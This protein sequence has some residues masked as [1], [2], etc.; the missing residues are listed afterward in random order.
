MYT[1]FRD[2]RIAFIF[3]GSEVCYQDPSD[4]RAAKVWVSERFGFTFGEWAAA[5]RGYLIPGRINFFTGDDYGFASKV[6][7]SMVTTVLVGYQEHYGYTPLEGVYNGCIVGEEGEV[8]LPLHKW[9]FAKAMW[10]K[11]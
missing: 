10:E 11:V 2:R 6:D 8:W 3:N 7:D 1:N 9:D 5:I 4:H